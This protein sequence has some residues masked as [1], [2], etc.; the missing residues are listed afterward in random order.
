VA[1]EFTGVPRDEWH[2]AL[3]RIDLIRDLV[4]FGL[5][6]LALLILTLI[7]KGVLTGLADLLPKAARG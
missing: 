2:H 3:D 6:L 4:I 5:A 7:D 1:D